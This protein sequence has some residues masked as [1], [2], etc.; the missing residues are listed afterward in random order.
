MS[1]KIVI[2][3]MGPGDNA[4][5]ADL[6]NAEKLGGLIARKQWTTLTGARQMGVMQAALKGAKQAGGETLGI[7]PGKDINDA[8]ED[9]DIVI[10][11]GMGSGRNIINVLSSDVVVACGMEAG[12]ASEVSLAIKEKKPV[13]LMT[14]NDAA[15]VFFKGLAPQL[16][17][18]ADT[19]EETIAQIEKILLAK[20]DRS[21]V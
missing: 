1:R 17:S 16:V 10:L 14:H 18:V 3:V 13:I 20:K 5:G 11:T 12:T 8:A 6:L 19:P 4:S 9:A 7:L 2:G 21:H 15:K